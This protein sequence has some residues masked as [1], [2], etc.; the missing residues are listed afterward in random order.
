MR[1][2]LR[3]AYQSTHVYNNLVGNPKLKHKYSVSLQEALQLS[4]VIYAREALHY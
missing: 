1:N 3:V 4:K 2:R